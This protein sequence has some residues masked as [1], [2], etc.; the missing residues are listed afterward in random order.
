LKQSRARGDIIE[1]AVGRAKRLASPALVAALVEAMVLEN[2]LALR[3]RQ[4]TDR[5]DETVAVKRRCFLGGR[6]APPH[7]LAQAI[8]KG[9]ACI[10]R[11][12]ERRGQ[13]LARRFDERGIQRCLPGVSVTEF[14]LCRAQGVLASLDLPQAPAP[15]A[16]YGREGL[17]HAARAPAALRR[18]LRP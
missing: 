5:R 15:I 7:R 6:H 11:G 4:Q 9:P 14:R 18:P 17:V 2:E 10:D 16:R 3:R 12:A 8:A 13:T 1:Q